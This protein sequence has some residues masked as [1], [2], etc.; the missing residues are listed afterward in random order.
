MKS[1]STDE[2]STDIGEVTDSAV[3]YLP[4]PITIPL[5]P[6][7]IKAYKRA[8]KNNG[9]L[10]YYLVHLMPL[11]PPKIGKT[12]FFHCLLNRNFPEGYKPRERN[13]KNTCDGYR[14]T[15][16]ATE[17]KAIEVS[18]HT[19]NS[20][21][22][23]DW[24]E[25][26]F[27]QE[28]ASIINGVH[29][30][31]PSE[32]SSLKETSVASSA[33]TNEGIRSITEGVTQ[34]STEDQAH[35]DETMTIFYTDL[36]GQP[37]FQEV[38]PALVAGPTIFL[39]MFS[40][41]DDLNKKYEVNY[42]PPSS[43]PHIE[44]DVY[45]Y[46]T[47]FTVID[48]IKECLSSIISFKDSQ[49]CNSRIRNLREK[50]ADFPKTYPIKVCMIG[51]QKD[52]LTPGKE[53]EEIEQKDSILRNI[54]TNTGI[55][56]ILEHYKSAEQLLIPI[57][58]Y[59]PKDGEIVR[60]KI[61]DT[62]IGDGDSSP[63]KLKIPVNWLGLE[64]YLRNHEKPTI[65]YAEC[66]EVA[67]RDFKIPKDDLKKCLYFLHHQT[68]TIRYF[69]DVKECK[70]IIITQPKVLF[71]AVTKL[72][73]LSFHKGGSKR[74]REFQT[75]GLFKTNE[76][77]SI[78]NE[79]EMGMTFDQCMALFK[80]LNILSPAHGLNTDDKYDFFLPCALLHVDR[81]PYD[82]EKEL[83]VL[84]PLLV[85]FKSGFVPL[86]VFGGLLGHFS[87]I[88]WGI[89]CSADKRPLL[90]RNQATFFLKEEKQ[91]VTLRKKPEYLQFFLHSSDN[92]TACYNIFSV[93]KVAIN[94]TCHILG[95][96]NSI[97]DKIKYGF[98]CT[99]NKKCIEDKDK[100]FAEKCQGAKYLELQCSV[101]KS[102]KIL[103][104]ERCWWFKPIGKL[105]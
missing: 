23:S 24:N 85:S 25:W 36:G 9:S 88:G 29:K 34:P 78:I 65:S 15:D 5:S 2:A 48:L 28:R 99:V 8:I 4:A 30:I 68:G 46:D 71:A 81:S 83:S 49:E 38:L 16:V 80:H 96:M 104:K 100:H 77:K 94:D 97:K 102:Q 41:Y 11:G 17:R 20:D 58:N 103:E 62:V 18:T 54:C 98:N 60:K 40:L 59:D 67:L 69:G 32:V 44:S 91:T 55:D 7:Y 90:Y 10:D 52:L 70:D 89:K 57:D 61:I 14:S 37:E 3:T 13:N 53:K 27:N 45:S 76:V 92:H 95:Y 50:I 31:S 1:I 72:I 75:R 56:D 33:D 26:S 79:E 105:S 43:E 6:D 39:P 19:I 74:I 93:I 22:S 35:Y 86:G 63:F 64:L 101:E 87:K 42:I 47:Q 73:T 66:E 82:I 84:D 21:T 12:C 51:T